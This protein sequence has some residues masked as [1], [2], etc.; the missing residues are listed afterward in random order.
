[1]AF[2]QITGILASFKD[3][4]LLNRITEYVPVDRQLNPV[5]EKGAVTVVL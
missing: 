1:M 5:N 4:V 3:Q 2:T